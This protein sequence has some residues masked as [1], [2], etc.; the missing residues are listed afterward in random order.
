[1]KHQLSLQSTALPAVMPATGK[2]KQG[3]QKNGGTDPKFGELLQ[4]VDTKETVNAKQEKAHGTQRLSHDARASVRMDQATTGQHDPEQLTDVDKAKEPAQAEQHQQAQ[5]ETST[6]AATDLVFLSIVAAQSLHKAFAPPVETAKQAA[7]EPEQIGVEDADASQPDAAT[8]KAGKAERLLSKAESTEGLTGSE[9]P[10]P[11]LSTKPEPVVPTPVNSK[12]KPEPLSAQ[13]QITLTVTKVE[14]ALLPVAPPPFTSGTTQSVGLLEAAAPLK[15]APALPETV[16]NGGVV[17]T[18]HFQLQPEHLGELKVSMH[19]KGDELRLTVEV[20]T[21]EAHAALQRDTSYLRQVMEKAGY[22][23]AEQ[24]VAVTLRLDPQSVQQLS[25]GGEASSFT[26]G[27]SGEQSF[28]AASHGQQQRQP[29]RQLD[30]E[31]GD[32]QASRNVQA[33]STVRAGTGVYL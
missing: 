24:S 11:K 14:T 13:P 2:V 1:M 27:N 23:V 8:R 30:K 6:P 16:P 31:Q 9:P 17:K 3:K 21:R 33:A 26:R 12:P 22:D 5:D 10:F 32:A 4:N 15:A 19:L 28:Q 29:S 18:L 20:T 25:S 7:A